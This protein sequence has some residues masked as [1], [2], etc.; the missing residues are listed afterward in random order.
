MIRQRWLPAVIVALAALPATRHAAGAQGVGL[1]QCE[2]CHGNREFIERRSDRQRADTLLYVPRSILEQTAHQSLSCA[3]CHEHYDDG[4]PHDAKAR[5]VPCETCHEQEGQDWDAS[6][7]KANA[8]TKGDAPRCT[9]CHGTHLIY[10]STDRRSKTHPLNVA[11]T[12]GRCHA[13]DRIIGTYFSTADKK[14]AS[15]A[16]ARYYETVHGQALKEAGLTVSATCNDCH[17]A[18]KVLPPDSPASSIYR[19]SIPVTCGRC[20]EGVVEVYDLSAHGVALA[21]GDTTSTGHA[22]PVCTDC[23]SGHG[24]VRA[25]EPSWHRGTVEECGTCHEQLYETYFETY[26]GKVTRLGSDLAATCA[27]CHTAHDM[28]R[29]TDTLS[30][31]NPRNVVATCR[32][33]HTQAAAGFAQYVPHADPHDR[34]K[35]PQLYWTWLAMSGLLAG[36][37][38]FFAIH[39]GLWLIRVA[40]DAR[41]SGGDRGSKGGGTEG[42]S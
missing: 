15:T 35:N 3:Q 1:V 32:K 36:V 33:C 13:D 6:I 24:I 14:T 38:G 18:H 39:T 10:K 22:A 27:D 4:Y 12:C 41:R 40:I 19:D 25:D 29:A 30:T 9:G 20:H 2:K 5:V 28:R 23:H 31:V 37:M 17:R 11:E 7:H 8:S 34:T 16:V 21:R 26:H 42:A